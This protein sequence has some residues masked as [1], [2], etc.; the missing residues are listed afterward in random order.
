[1]NGLNPPVLLTPGQQVTFSVRFAPQSAGNFSGSVSITSDASNPSLSVPLSGTGT[2]IPPGQLAVSPTSINFGNVTVG[3]NAQQ[4]G[5]LT[6]SGNSVTVSSY[7]LVGAPFAISGLSLPVTIAAGQHV[8]F[9]MTFTPTGNGVVS[10]SVTFNSDASNSPT[11]ETLTGTGVPP[12][13]H[14]VDLSWTASTSNN[15]TGYNIYRGIKN[16]GPYGKI[17]S[18]LNASTQYSDTTVSNGVTYYYVTTAVNSSNEESG[19]SN[20]TTAVIP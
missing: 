19:Y 2:A 16:G 20:Q 3:Q 11:V 12:A 17:N 9:T 1:M 7:N 14:S 8:Q 4:N 5:T 13:Q 15:I 10:G 18:V 6:A